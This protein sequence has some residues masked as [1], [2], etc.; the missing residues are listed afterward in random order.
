MASHTDE[1]CRDQTREKFSSHADEDCR[2]QAREEFS[3]HVG[4]PSS[5]YDFVKVRVHTSFDQNKSQASQT[6]QPQEG[7]SYFVFSR[8]LLSRQLTAAGLNT[9]SS[10]RCALS[11][12]K[13]LVDQNRLDISVSE[14]NIL[15]ERHIKDELPSGQ[16]SDILASCNSRPTLIL[17]LS[18]PPHSSLST[19][20]KL[21][22]SR[23][24][25]PSI[26]HTSSAWRTLCSIK[27][28][29]QNREW[30]LNEWSDE[31]V[32][33]EVYRR[34]KM[35]RKALQSMLEQCINQGRSIII[36]GM[37][38]LHEL[39]RVDDFH[40]HM[41]SNTEGH[42]MHFIRVAFNIIIEPHQQA[43]L[44]HNE[45]NR[46]SRT[47]SIGVVPNNL[48]KF[49]SYFSNLAHSIIATGMKINELQVNE[50]DIHE[51]VS[52]CHAIVLNQIKS[53]V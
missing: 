41:N 18:G 15:L 44:M 21:L 12:K 23:L 35:V 51:L 50:S 7:G 6:N 27:P 43:I 28:D 37:E 36:E 26:V 19:L 52:S 20:A 4:L 5:K 49:N 53:I 11:L 34:G 10:L 47:D 45:K 3:S 17:T 40:D 38:C 25:I 42:R 24:S 14:F 22:S 32:A 9:E 30:L 31:E 46:M 2:D 29:L 1:D 48:K 16:I 39:Y 8:Y 33:E 13:Y